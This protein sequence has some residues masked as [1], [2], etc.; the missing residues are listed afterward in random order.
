MT[1]ATLYLVSPTRGERRIL[2]IAAWATARVEA[3]IAIRAER[4]ELALDLLRE[5]QTRR[6][7]PR[8]V[9][10]ALTHLGLPLR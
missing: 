6:Q 8:A 1:A 3:R 5:Q 9:D 2:R 4:R 7:D 10:I